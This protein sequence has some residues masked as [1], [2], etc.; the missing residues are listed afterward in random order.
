MANFPFK[1]DLLI[2][3]KQ[4]LIKRCQSPLNYIY[5]CIS[6]YPK[7]VG[8]ALTETQIEE[9]KEWVHEKNLIFE[10]CWIV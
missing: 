10:L 1:D 7:F 5:I 4:T 9:V 6:I 8:A 2:S 3:S